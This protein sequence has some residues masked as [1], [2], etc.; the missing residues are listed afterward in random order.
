MD[1]F[2]IAA[3]AAAVLALLAI[4]GYRYIAACNRR[5]NEKVDHDAATTTRE[6]L[7]NDQYGATGERF[8]YGLH[9]AR[10]NGCEAIAVHNAK[11]ALGMDSTLS[12]T[13]ADF[14][15]AFAM[16]GYGFFGSNPRA[17]GRVLR[18][19]GIGY[20]R[21]GRHELTRQG[22]YILAFWNDRRPWGGL[23]TVAM[24]CDGGGYTTYNLKGRGMVSA[25]PP[26]VYA[27]HYICGYYLGK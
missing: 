10:R 6:R 7:I 22:V 11:V 26:A 13:M 20:I 8:I 14:H 23:H 5:H 19:S 27:R 24:R 2:A 3:A 12:Q 21:V 4:L 15:R 1:G 16:I 9:R 18:C 25:L 17:I